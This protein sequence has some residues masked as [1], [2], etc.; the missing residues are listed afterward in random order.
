MAAPPPSSCRLGRSRPGR[1]GTWALLLLLLLAGSRRPPAPAWDS[2]PCT[3]LGPS[4]R[5]R[6]PRHGRW[7]QRAQTG[8]LL[9]LLRMPGQGSRRAP[10][11]A[12]R[13]TPRGASAAAVGSPASTPAMRE[14]WRVSFMQ[15]ECRPAAHEQCD[16]CERTSGLQ[17]SL[18]C[19]AGMFMCCSHWA[20]PSNA[21]RPCEQLLWPSPAPA[22]LRRRTPRPRHTKGLLLAILRH[23][24]V[25]LD[26]LALLEAA[27][28]GRLYVAL[29]PRHGQRGR[30]GTGWP[31]QLL[32]RLAPPPPCMHAC[33]C[34]LAAAAAP[35]RT[36]WTNTSSSHS[37]EVMKP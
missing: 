27:V 30:V 4:S 24:Q 16:R 32:A 5:R 33:R 28:A 25:K 1:A 35:R 6:A 3:P 37:S 36:W 11:P 23:N 17:R 21:S 14:R 18:H 34:L 20:A 22:H 31:P 7:P 26:F 12:P 19:R 8:R 15:D 9:L 10:R 2:I 13:R 29:Q